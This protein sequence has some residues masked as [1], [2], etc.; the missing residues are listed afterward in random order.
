MTRPS[1]VA[2]GPRQH[3]HQFPT[4]SAALD[5]TR[6]VPTTSS[7]HRRRHTTTTIISSSGGQSDTA[8][9]PHSRH[10][11]GHG[12]ARA[13]ARHGTARG[14]AS[15]TRETGR[16]SLSVGPL[17]LQSFE[18]FGLSTTA[19]RGFA[20]SIMQIGVDSVLNIGKFC[21]FFFCFV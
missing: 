8:A 16:G 13:A 12:Q 18:Q 9:R 4:P 19:T 6:V 15:S 14:T 20:V 3:T 2:T 7:T 21:V 1:A 10:S 17:S 11:R 5:S